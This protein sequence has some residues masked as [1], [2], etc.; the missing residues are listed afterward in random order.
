MSSFLIRKTR[1]VAL[2]TEWLSDDILRWRDVIGRRHIAYYPSVLRSFQSH[3][4]SD[5]VASLCFTLT[6]GED[7]RTR[8][9]VHGKVVQLQLT[10]GVDGQP[11]R[12]QSHGN[13]HSCQLMLALRAFGMW[14]CHMKEQSHSFWSKYTVIFCART[15]KFYSGGIYVVITSW[16]WG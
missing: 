6:A 16:I 13:T 8:V 14:S 10:L 7:Q 1:S 5:M 15:K 11:G 4:R 2:D 3:S 12:G 9:L